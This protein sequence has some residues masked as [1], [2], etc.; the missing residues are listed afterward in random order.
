MENS[1]R[2]LESP[3]WP[4]DILPP[5]DRDKAERGRRLYAAQCVSCH[6]L[7]ERD[8]PHREV[9][10]MVTGL[11]VVGT[12]PTSAMNLATARI[13]SGKLE[14]GS[15]WNGGTY[16][17]EE[18]ALRILFDL[19]SRSLARQP[20]AAVRTSVAARLH[21]LSKAEKQGQHA[22]K[23]EADTTAD[24]RAYKARPLNGA[25]ASSPYL[26][27]GSVP[28]LYDLLLPPAERPARFAVGRLEYD[29]RKV[30]YVSDGEVPWV[31]DTTVK[32]NS[33]QGHE[34]GTTLTDDER[35]ALVEYLKTL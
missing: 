18:P 1:L 26:H 4:E 27:N 12:D 7:I 30:G 20:I 13:P 35:W 25:W 16:G 28:T 21:H 23:T 10:A 6:A 11:D 9:I 19:V 17:A 14:G 2:G 34:L 8:D 33:N 32:G 31:L 29:P 3:V 5:I 22:R 24:L 15:A